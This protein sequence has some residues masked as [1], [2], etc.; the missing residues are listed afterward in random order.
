MASPKSPRTN[1]GKF[2]KGEGLPLHQRRRV[3]DEVDNHY[4]VGMMSKSTWLHLRLPFSFFL[5]PVFILAW[6]IQPLEIELWRLIVSFICLHLFLYPASNAF[7]S[8]FDKDEGSIGGLKNPPPVTKELYHWAQIFDIIALILAYILSPLMAVMVLIYGLVSRAYS[9][10]SVRL[11]KYPL[12]GWLIVGIFQGFITVWICFEGLHAT[13]LLMLLEPE[14][15]IPSLLSTLMLW[16]G[17][18]M[19]QIYQHEEDK[20]RGDNTI[21]LFLGIK[22]TFYLTAGVYFFAISGFVFYYLTNVG[23]NHAL[24]YLFGLSPLLFYFLW[25]YIKVLKDDKEA[26]FKNTMQLNVLSSIC[27]N[28]VFFV[29]GLMK[30]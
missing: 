28:L 5:M 2:S 1:G 16:G 8:Y 19:T 7:N 12:L 26:N 9:H 29:S 13:G 23:Y 17:Y 18:P 10:P 11:K 25:W 14:V 4:I 6:S 27:A 24:L 15:Y 21:S 30:F 3:G 22:G 20:K